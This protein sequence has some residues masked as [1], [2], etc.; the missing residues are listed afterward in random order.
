MTLRTRR[1][2][3][4]S[5]IPCF[6]VGGAA[7][8]LYSQ[9][10]R[11]DTDTREVTKIGALYVRGYP[12]DAHITLDG[13]PLN[14][15]S[16]WPLQS[17]TLDG[18]LVPGTYKLHAEAP[19][20]RSWDADVVIKP[21]L[22]TERKSLVLFPDIA[23]PVPLAS[24]TVAVGVDAPDSFDEPVVLTSND[25]PRALVGEVSVAG[26]YL[27]T[28]NGRL[29]LTSTVTRGKT[30]SQLLSLRAPDEDAATTVSL[31]GSD[32]L[33][34]IQDDSVIHRESARLITAY[35]GSTGRRSTL[36]STTE[37]NSIGA[38]LRTSSHD[39]WNLISA[40]SSQL[41]V[42]RRG[43]TNRVIV[44]IKDAISIQQAGSSLGVLDAA[45][46][47]WLVDPDTGA[48]KE[49]GHRARFATW[50]DDGS[51]VAAYI[52]S[53]I[54]V[55]ALE[56]DAPSGKLVGALPTGHDVE[57]ISW[58][59]DGEHIFLVSRDANRNLTMTFADVIDGTES[60]QH[61]YRMPLTSDW[62]YSAKQGT[63]Y[64]ISEGKVLSYVFP[65]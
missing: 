35:D 1:I 16:W 20:Y 43:S 49:I 13:E 47:L 5:L 24:G 31:Q 10:Y 60:E 63:L 29:A 54:E 8:V 32:A 34:S 45:G 28:V 58:Y 62:A 52:D 40:T 11:I 56:T 15:G 53:G 50:K 51:A 48:R 7:A 44:P 23:V 6:V 37:A 12:R 41:V 36:A 55:I 14:T 61:V 17:G 22:V 38:Y 2:F 4:W 27:G 39:A 21:S 46:S 30:M 42:K 3:F 18:G 65:D 57:S 64:L 33:P 9:G 19:G 26:T 59:P 25:N